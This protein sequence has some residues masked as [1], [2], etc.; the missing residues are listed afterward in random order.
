MSPQRF[1]GGVV[2]EG[3]DRETMERE[4]TVDEQMARI[5]NDIT[6]ATVELDEKVILYR[7]A[8]RQALEEKQR[9]TNQ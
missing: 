6:R 9:K 8:L 7:R 5:D 3:M 2:P 4:Q 1:G